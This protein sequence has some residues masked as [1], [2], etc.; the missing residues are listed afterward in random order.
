MIAVVDTGPINYLVVI[1]EIELLPL[2]YQRVFLPPSVRQELVRPRAPEI[3]RAWIASAPAWLEV[4]AASKSPDEHLAV[5]DAGERDVI[6]VARELK[7]VQVVIDEFRARQEAQRRQLSVTGTVG[8]L[9]AG[10][11]KGLVSLDKAL[12]RL[13]QTNFRISPDILNRLKQAQ[14][15]L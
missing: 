13:G 6:L 2:L 15:L 5:L 12:D 3:V 14:N 11:K 10:S 8:V 9:A 7:G 1:G 4:R